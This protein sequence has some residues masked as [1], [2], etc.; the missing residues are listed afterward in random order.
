MNI[1]YL[2]IEKTDTE[3]IKIVPVETIHNP[4]DGA[5]NIGREINYEMEPLIIN[6]K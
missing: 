3:Y 6:L 4:V 5:E 1:N 2:L